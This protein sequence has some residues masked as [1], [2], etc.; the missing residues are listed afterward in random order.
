MCTGIELAA[1]LGGTALNAVGGM[2]Q[3]NEEAAN[4]K[5]MADARNEKLQLTLNKN[6]KLAERS[7]QRFDARQQDTQNLDQNEQ[8]AKQDR[9][10]TLEQAVTDTPNPTPDLPISG[11][12]PTVVRT[13]LAKRVGEAL[14]KAKESATKLG[15]LGG[16]GDLWVNQGFKDAQAGRDIGVDANLA[17]GNMALLPYQQD[18]AE[19]RAYQP[20]S[21][22]GGI[23]QGI[24]SGLSSFGGGGGRL[25]RRSYSSPWG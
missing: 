4:Q 22:L 11:S 2:I 9:Q 13:E 17:A 19:T 12:A 1:M 10:Q 18:I 8:K 7:R 25:P 6:D 3:R 5:R 20:I 15:T 14:S 21:P 24:G 16:Y 23:L